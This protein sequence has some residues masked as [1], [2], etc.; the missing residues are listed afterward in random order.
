MIPITLIDALK[1]LDQSVIGDRPKPFELVFTTGDA[2][3]GTGGERIVFDRAVLVTKRRT[4]AVASIDGKKRSRDKRYPV[5]IKNLSSH[6]I[7]R[8]NVQLIERINGHIVL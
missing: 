4:S 1:I 7:R 3:R 5:L 6:E 8:V 2:K